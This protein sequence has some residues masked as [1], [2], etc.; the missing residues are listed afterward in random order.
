MYRN[1][2]RA[3]FVKEMSGKN[4]VKNKKDSPRVIHARVV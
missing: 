1:T 4:F 2:A 3:L